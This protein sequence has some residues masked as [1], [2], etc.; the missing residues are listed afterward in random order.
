MLVWTLWSFP[1]HN[2]S[3]ITHTHTIVASMDFDSHVKSP[4]TKQT[5]QKVK[6]KNKNEIN[7]DA[8]S[9]NKNQWQTFQKF[10][11]VRLFWCCCCRSPSDSLWKRTFAKKKANETSSL[12]VRTNDSDKCTMC[13]FF[14]CQVDAKLKHFPHEMWFNIKFCTHR[15]NLSRLCV[16]SFIYII[17]HSCEAGVRG[18][19]HNNK[20]AEHIDSSTSDK[21]SDVMREKKKVRNDE[22]GL[23]N[24]DQILKKILFDNK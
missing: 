11:F 20:S 14:F 9:A 1:E 18:T 3:N 7:K 6:N 4:K 5:K 16:V 12:F 24:F 17:Y 8:K 21:N 19:A 23:S 10:S 15:C 22:I 13:D 2:N